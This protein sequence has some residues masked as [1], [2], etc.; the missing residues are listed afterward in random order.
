MNRCL[1]LAAVVLLA[2]GTLATPS[3]LRA[4]SATILAQPTEPKIDSP[5]LAALWLE[6]TAGNVA[7]LDSFWQEIRGKAPLVEP[8]PEDP[9]LM[10][11][12]FIRR[13]SEFTHSTF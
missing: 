7:A 9:K 13:G 2:L 5:R 6:I 10:R 4:Q 3:G 11:V 1:T 8:N 12:T